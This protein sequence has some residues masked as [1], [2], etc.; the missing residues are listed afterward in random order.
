[1]RKIRG[2][3]LVEL[4]V[5][6]GIIAVL[7]S[8]LL[9]ALTKARQ[10]A[11]SVACLFNLRQLGMAA[12]MYATDNRDVMPAWDTYYWVGSS[13][14]GSQSWWPYQLA[15]YLGRKDFAYNNKTR[16]KVSLYQCPAADQAN[17]FNGWWNDNCPVNYAISVLS[18]SG[19]HYTTNWDWHNQGGPRKYFWLKRNMVKQPETF[20]VFGDLNKGMCVVPYFISISSQMDNTNGSGTPSFRH[21]KSN[22]NGRINVVFL[23]GHAES[24]LR[25]EF[26]K[27]NCSYANANAFGRTDWSPGP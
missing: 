13:F 12:G 10:A 9:P 19:M 8:I 2:F 7:I 21:G 15:N 18:S 25:G 1:M 23:D 16:N 6:I 24:L 22:P 17:G 26:M 4:L 3:T 20:W 11:I 27:V 5:V 14:N